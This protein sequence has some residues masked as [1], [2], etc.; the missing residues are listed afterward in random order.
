[1]DYY[2]FDCYLQFFVVVLAGCCVQGMIFY[3]L[4]GFTHCL[5]C[6][7][8]IYRTKLRNLYNIKGSDC[9]DCLASFFCPHMALC[10]EYRELKAR[11]F[12]MSA[13]NQNTIY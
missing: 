7:A 4:G 5:S 11:G 12:D 9:G 8:C 3:I 1:M 13:G 2:V 6:Y 10:Q